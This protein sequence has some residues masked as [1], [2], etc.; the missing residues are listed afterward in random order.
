MVGVPILYKYLLKNY[1]YIEFSLLCINNRD[2]TPF[3]VGSRD[4]VWSLASPVLGGSL[5]LS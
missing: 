5:T 1:L 2:K 3:G 4:L